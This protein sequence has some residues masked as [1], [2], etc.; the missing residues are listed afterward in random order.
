MD[1]SN[2]VQ[3][4]ADQTLSAASAAANFLPEP[5]ARGVDFARS[6]LRADGMTSTTVV[7]LSPEYQELI[8]KQIETQ[9]EVQQ[10]TLVSNV[11]RSKHEAKMAP[12]RNVRES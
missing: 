8:N 2:T 9:L 5:V 7:D 3:S 10:V 6:L 12:I 11:E 4:I 1:A